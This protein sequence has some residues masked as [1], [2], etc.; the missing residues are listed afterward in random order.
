MIF[1]Q[2]YQQ[3][4]SYVFL[5]LSALDMSSIML[6]LLS[7]FLVSLLPLVT[8]VVSPTEPDTD[9]PRGLVRMVSAD[10]HS[11]SNN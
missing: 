2:K 5:F 1:T 9:L 7:L 11:L 3:N 10:S 4:Q 8:G 6:P